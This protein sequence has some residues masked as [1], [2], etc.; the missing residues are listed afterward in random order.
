MRRVRG[1]EGDRVRCGAEWASAFLLLFYGQVL[2]LPEAWVATGIMLAL[3]DD[4]QEL[5]MVAA[6]RRGEKPDDGHPR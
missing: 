6:A 1:I 2:G 5:T 4:G 3:A